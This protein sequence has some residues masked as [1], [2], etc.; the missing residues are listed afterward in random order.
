MRTDCSAELCPRWWNM[1]LIL[2]WTKLAKRVQRASL[3][4][5]WQYAAVHKITRLCPECT[6]SSAGADLHTP[7][8]VSWMVSTSM[9]IKVLHGTRLFDATLIFHLTFN[10]L[11]ASKT[12]FLNPKS[13]PAL[14]PISSCGEVGFI[15]LNTE[16]Q[17]DWKDKGAPGGPKGAKRRVR[18][19]AAS[20]DKAPAALRLPYWLSKCKL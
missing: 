20:R 7:W 18:K 11:M 14:F 9:D 10:Y 8:T 3:R 6:C 17:A 2:S 13:K 5:A 4:R 12:K 16:P 1:V 15:G 19:Q